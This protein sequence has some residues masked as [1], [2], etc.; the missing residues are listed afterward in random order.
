MIGKYSN[1]A[2][3]IL[4][5]DFNAVDTTLSITPLDVAKFPS[6]SETWDYFKLIL[7]D[8]ASNKYEIVKVISITG[9]DFTVLRAQ[10]GTTA[11]DWLANNEIYLGITKQ[12]LLD[13]RKEGSGGNEVVKSANFVLNPDEVA[14]VI[15]MDTAGIVAT[16]VEMTK[17]EDF[18][19]LRFKNTSGDD[20]ALNPFGTE[21]IEGQGGFIIP[22]MNSC[23]VYRDGAEWKVFSLTRF[24]E[25]ANTQKYIE[26]LLLERPDVDSIVLGNGICN[27]STGQVEMI[28]SAPLTAD[29]NHAIGTG[30]GGQ[31][32]TVAKTG[33]FSSVGTAITGV[34]TLFLTEFKVGDV[35]WS[36]SNGEGHVIINISSDLNMVTQ[37]G[38]T[39]DV[40]GE[41]VNKNGLAMFAT[42]HTFL[43]YSPTADTHRVVFDTAV[44]CENALADA[45]MTGYTIYRR[46]GS[47]MTDA[48]KA[49]VDF[50]A[51]EISGG[52]VK[53]GY[54]TK[55][56][57]FSISSTSF[58]SYN[59]SIPQGIK[60]DVLMEVSHSG[61][62]ANNRGE[63][64]TNSNFFTNQTG[65]YTG[66]ETIQ[67]WWQ[68]KILSLDGTI[69]ARKVAGTN[70]I[71]NTLE[72]TDGRT[73]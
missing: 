45:G 46:V 7:R 22:A 25:R 8:I 3:S 17:F 50:T 5:A 72:Y 34:G 19:M 4:T 40:S 20:V 11:E 1:N 9:S 67:T 61:L 16:F 42:Y 24:S 59:L 21:S 33:T 23:E 57:D 64:R 27:D 52:G 35:L 26:G 37:L 13:N 56:Q 2:K 41:A 70:F 54:A 55:I 12:D 48:V 51:T 71:G 60:L 36:S 15:T 49:V 65:S 63:L 31:P 66:Y 73:K 39:V 69:E 68:V 29:T 62:N 47:I 14:N 10:E 43:T 53:I 6:I 28:V 38:F 32:T 18:V 58:A 44:N 30:D